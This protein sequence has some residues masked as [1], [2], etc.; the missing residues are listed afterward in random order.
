MFLLADV[1]LCKSAYSASC[2]LVRPEGFEPPTY[3]I[4]ARYSDPL[5]Y[6]RIVWYAQK[7]LNLRPTG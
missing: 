1:Y 2:E 5:S 4:E 7:G 6:G 3:E